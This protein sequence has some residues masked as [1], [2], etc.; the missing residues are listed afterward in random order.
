MSINKVN[1]LTPSCQ[2]FYLSAKANSFMQRPIFWVRESGAC[3]GVRKVVAV[4]IAVLL[5]MTLIG[6]VVVI[7]GIKEYGRQ[8]TPPLLKNK[9]AQELMCFNNRRVKGQVN[10]V[11]ITTNE[12][13]LEAT[14]QTLKDHPRP[15]QTTLHIG[16]AAWHNL[17]MMCA[18][19]SDYG[20]II[21]FN[22]KNAEFMEKTMELV[23]LSDSRELFVQKIVGYL[24]G[25]QG[26]E[27]RIFFHKDQTG[28]PTERIEQELRREASWLGSDENYRFVR[29]LACDERLVALTE[30]ITHWETFSQMRAYFD[31]SGLVVDT[32][33]LSNICQF[34]RTPAKEEA[35][36]KTVECLQSKETLLISCPIVKAG[37]T[38]LE[39]SVAIKLFIR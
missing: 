11:Y 13:N 2:S 22:P 23:K 17:D 10:G 34:M 26:E 4:V 3:A 32:L 1:Y 20:L 25:L 14:A 33:Y 6:L 27:R 21:D 38:N 35:Y 31:K 12:S 16:C 15:S 5:S 19:R 18:R 9:I 28:L 37:E 39:Q 30:D 36:K 7:P 8:G 29:Q 24:N